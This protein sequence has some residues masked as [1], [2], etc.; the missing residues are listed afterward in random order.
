[1]RARRQRSTRIA[2]L[3]APPPAAALQNVQGFM[4]DMMGAN[5]TD[6]LPASWA[7]PSFDWSRLGDFGEGGHS[8]AQR[9]TAWHG[10]PLI[11]PQAAHPRP[12]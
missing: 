4:H 7:S 1:M 8:V 11:G 12:A 10:L 5:W 2:G 6:F 9:V 3:P